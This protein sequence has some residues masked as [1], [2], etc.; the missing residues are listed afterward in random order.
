MLEHAVGSGYDARTGA[1]LNIDTGTFTYDTLGRVSQA[2]NPATS[3][4]FHYDAEGRLIGGSSAAVMDTGT[5]GAALVTPGSSRNVSYTYEPDGKTAQDVFVDAALTQHTRQW[6]WAQQ[7]LLGTST[8]GRADP[9]NADDIG[10]LPFVSP[11]LTIY[12]RELNGL[13][14]SQ[15]NVTGH[16][17]WAAPNPYEEPCVTQ[18]PPPATSG[19]VAPAD[20]SYVQIPLSGQTNDGSN[21]TDS[22]TMRSTMQ[23]SAS[24]MTPDVSSIAPYAA[25]RTSDFA[26]CWDWMDGEGIWHTGDHSGCGGGG[27]QGIGLGGGVNN[28]YGGRGGDRP[29]VPKPQPAPPP[30]VMRPPTYKPCNNPIVQSYGFGAGWLIGGAVDVTYNA[31]SFYL[32]YGVTM[33]TTPHAGPSK[34]YGIVVPNQGQS[35]ADVLSGYSAGGSL[36]GPPGSANWSFNGSGNVYSVS[37]PGGVPAATG[38][39]MWTKGPYTMFMCVDTPATPM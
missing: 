36:T 29:R 11:G 27:F 37:T 39:F 9:Q 35:N 19:F 1:P 22:S 2:A 12:D 30:H 38:S 18:S 21:L 24:A 28:P 5:C 26:H 13:V 31:G 7:T 4:T 3:A 17:A 25:R 15:H 8:D 14:S 23:T 10:I 6:H 20:N 34:T 16:A 32:N 33:S